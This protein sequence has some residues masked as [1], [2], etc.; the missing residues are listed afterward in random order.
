MINEIQEA[1]DNYIRCHTLRT[2]KDIIFIKQEDA[3][4]I[5]RKTGYKGVCIDVSSATT[6]SQVVERVANHVAVY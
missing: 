1:I 2:V 4:V 5:V 6:P 3:V